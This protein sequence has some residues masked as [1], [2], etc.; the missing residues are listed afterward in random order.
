[1]VRRRTKEL[2]ENNV[3][4]QA[5]LAELEKLPPTSEIPIV[6]SELK[7]SVRFNLMSIVLFFAMKIRFSRNNNKE[8]SFF[9]LF[10]EVDRTSKSLSSIRK[11]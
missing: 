10:L 4:I 3:K 5:E 6:K 8:G 11:R 1:V 7:Q 9:V 2:K